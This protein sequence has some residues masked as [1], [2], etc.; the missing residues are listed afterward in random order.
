MSL[1]NIENLSVAYSGIYALRSINIFVEKGNVVSVLGPNGA[2]KPLFY[3][4]F[5]V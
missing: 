4:Q 1:L 3:R 5:L 2:G